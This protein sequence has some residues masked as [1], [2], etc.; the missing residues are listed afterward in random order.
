MWPHWGKLTD[1]TTVLMIMTLAFAPLLWWLDPKYSYISYSGVQYPLP[2]MPAIKIA[3]WWGGDNAL[4]CKFVD[5]A[6]CFWI[7]GLA[8]GKGFT[9]KILGSN[10]M[11]QYLSP[12]AYS[13]YLF[14]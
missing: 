12:A 11:V 2:N 1:L 4:G 14:Q 8:V 13:V 6:L 5:F 3:Q 7:Y 9:A 10:F